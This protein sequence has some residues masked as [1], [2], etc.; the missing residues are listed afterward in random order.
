MVI[1]SLLMYGSLINYL[2]GKEIVGQSTQ[3]SVSYNIVGMSVVALIGPI[4]GLFAGIY[5]GRYKAVHAGVWMMWTASAVDVLLFTLQWFLPESQQIL[6]Y[7]GFL[8][9]AVVSFVGLALFLVNSVPFGLD[10]MPDASGGQISAFIH[11][12]VCLTH[13]VN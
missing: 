5:C 1:W 10:Q 13:A 11:L 4:A 6:S 3:S 8:I 7:S 2:A 9:A 12:Y